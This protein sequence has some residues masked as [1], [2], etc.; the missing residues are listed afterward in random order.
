MYHL[1][2]TT[3]LSRKNANRLGTGQ[4]RSPQFILSSKIFGDCHDRA[5][6]LGGPRCGTGNMPNFDLPVFS[7]EE[8]TYWIV[9]DKIDADASGIEGA[10]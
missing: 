7:T 5:K 3:T 10:L 4:G 1:I 6:E 2:A 9:A 8:W